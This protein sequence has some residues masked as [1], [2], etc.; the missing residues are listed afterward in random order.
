MGLLQASSRK[1]NTKPGRSSCA[2][3]LEDIIASSSAACSGPF[4]SLS[5]CSTWGSWIRD[6]SSDCI[7]QKLKP[8]PVDGLLGSP[9]CVWLQF[10]R[11]SKRP[12][13]A[14]GIAR[15]LAEL[16]TLL[17]IAVASGTSATSGPP[18]ENIRTSVPL[19]SANMGSSSSNKQHR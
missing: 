18:R 8:D 10:T 5:A 12:N 11:S 3:M 7:Q 19:C 13:P 16:E 4:S 2:L 15:L 9:N 17:D 6:S 14:C 1:S